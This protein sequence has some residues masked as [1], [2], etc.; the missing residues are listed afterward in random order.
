MNTCPICHR[1]LGLTRIQ[2]A[3]IELIHQGLGDKSIAL[4]KG[5]S[6]RAVK[7]MTQRIREALGIKGSSRGELILAIAELKRRRQESSMSS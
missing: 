5:V 2:W 4:T 6:V 7:S 3:H 1:V